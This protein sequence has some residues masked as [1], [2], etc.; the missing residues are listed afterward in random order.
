MCIVQPYSAAKEY[1]EYIYRLVQSSNLIPDKQQ[2]V[3]K[4]V[5]NATF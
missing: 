3:L 4:A 5:D 2:V 1:V